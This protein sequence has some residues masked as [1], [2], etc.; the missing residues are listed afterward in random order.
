M[1]GQILESEAIRESGTILAKLVLGLVL[2]GLIG[3]E[4]ERHGRPAG[5]RTHMLM[6]MGVVLLCEASKAWPGA[7]DARIA[8]QIVTGVGF[9]GAGTIMRMGIEV[10]GLTTAAS[11]WSAAAI[12]FAVSLGGS[13]LLVAV[14]ATALAL[15]TLEGVDRL[16]KRM[17]RGERRRQLQLELESSDVL[18]RV[19]AALEEGG[20]VPVSVQLLQ[21]APHLRV[22][23][24]FEE[25][26]ESSPELVTLVMKVPGVLGAHDGKHF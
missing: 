9:L 11:L 8:A 14:G 25:G 18:P 7:D 5:I 12:G 24:A 10:R 1:W 23:L 22:R 15:L 16:E 17:S 6:V 19:M 3:L 20:V 21:R 2:G 13:F 26:L 4:R